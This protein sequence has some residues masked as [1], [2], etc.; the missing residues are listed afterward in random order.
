[1]LEQAINELKQHLYK[2]AD[3]YKRNINDKALQRNI[4]S[5]I[6]AIN[7]LEKQAYGRAITNE[8][9]L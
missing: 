5:L 6:D 7:V 9:G 4:L 8:W 1:V 3:E 2:S